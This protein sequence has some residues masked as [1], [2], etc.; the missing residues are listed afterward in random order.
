M[1]HLE[2]AIEIDP[3]YADAYKNIGV[4]HAQEGRMDE[5]IANWKKALEINPELG[6]AKEYIKPAERLPR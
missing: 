5:A 2:R 1:A 4:L 6:S 3:N